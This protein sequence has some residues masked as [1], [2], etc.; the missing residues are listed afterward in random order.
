MSSVYRYLPNYSAKSSVFISHQYTAD[1]VK[2]KHIS[3]QENVLFECRIQYIRI[4][5]NDLGHSIENVH[6]V[7][8]NVNNQKHYRQFQASNMKIR[9]FICTRSFV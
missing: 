7:E 4:L 2:K 8:L 5:F 1:I 9:K 6:Y 3:A